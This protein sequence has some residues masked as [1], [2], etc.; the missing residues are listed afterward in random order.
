MA[1]IPHIPAIFP[2]GD[3]ALTIDF[4]NQ[5]DEQLHARVIALQQVLQANP[6]PGILEMVPAYSSLTLYYDYQALS[7]YCTP[8]QTIYSWLKS[9][10]TGRLDTGITIQE[11]GSRLIRVPVCYEGAMAPDLPALE[12]A[13]GL[14]AAEIIRIHTGTR[15]RVYMLGFLPGFAYMAT[16]DERIAMPRKTKPRNIAAGSVGIAGLQTGIYPLASPGGWQII[17]RTPLTLFDKDR[18]DPALF[19]AGDQVEFYSIKESEF[20]TYSNT[21]AWA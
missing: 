4:G 19:R 2:L 9:A 17:G 15:Y 18:E 5:P 10:V 6:L 1:S 7:K 3:H 8:G 14:T 20:S 16:L 13:T 12:A 21:Q 11:A